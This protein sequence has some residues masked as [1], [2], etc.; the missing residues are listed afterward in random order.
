MTTGRFRERYGP[1]ALVTGASDGIGRAF[2]GA[3]AAR[4]L[5]LIL[6]AR[7]EEVLAAVAADLRTR[8]GVRAAT[9]PADLARPE[10]VERVLAATAG[11]AVGLMVAAAGFGTSGPVLE[12]DPAAELAMIDVNCRAVVALTHGIGRRMAG[13]ATGGIVLLGSIVAFQGVARAATY[14]A[15]KA[16][17]QSFA[18][19][20]GRELAPSGVDVLAVAPGPVASGFA[21]RAGMRMGRAQ[22]PASVAAGALDALGRRRTVRPGALSRLLGWS[23]ATLPRPARVGVMSAIM[24]GMTPDAGARR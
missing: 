20:L 13:R 4:G 2:A 12:A 11:E 24:A 18:E 10:G 6:V 1:V 16:F 5:D 9:V 19:G 7:R 14:A 8:H 22:D 21:A 15:T 17:V 3:L 23:L